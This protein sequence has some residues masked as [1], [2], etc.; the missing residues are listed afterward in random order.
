MTLTESIS[1]AGEQSV[2]FFR[3]L[4]ASDIMK[5]I[6][7]GVYYSRH[8][9]IHS[10]LIVPVGI[11]VIFTILYGLNIFLTDVIHFRF[12]SS[13]LGMLINLVI[14]C[15]MSV[16]SDLD[17]EGKKGRT[18][19]KISQWS[20]WLL[21][22]YLSLIKPSMNFTLKW[23]NVFFIPSFIILPLSSPITF[24]EC[25]KIAGVFVVGFLLLLCI[26]VYLLLGLQWVL[27]RYGLLS[28]E[29]T[30]AQS[31]KDDAE[32]EEEIELR[33]MNSIGSNQVFTS[34]RDD[35]TTIDISSLRSVNE[36][37]KGSTRAATFSQSPF[38]PQDGESSVLQSVNPQSIQQPEPSYLRSSG[39]SVYRPQS[40]A[41]S[42]GSVISREE[43]PYSTVS[44]SSDS[45]S[46]STVSYDLSDN[47]KFITIFITKYVDWILYLLLFFVSLPFYYVSSIHVFLPYHLGITVISYYLALLIPQKWP[48]TKK[49]AHPILILTAEILFVCFIGSLIYHHG[50]PRGFLDDLEYYKT[51]KT[52]LNLFNNKAMLNNGK[53]GTLSLDFTKTPKWPGCGDILSSLMDVSIVA[54]SLPMFSYRRDFVQNFWVLMPP[55]VVSICLTFFLYPV[56]CYHIGIQSERAIGFIGRSVT[57]A[58]GTPLI[59]SLDGSISLMAVCTI[60]SGICGVLVGD[61]LFK[62][63]RVSKGD[64]VTRGV[65][66]GINC[67]A[68]A[69]AHLLNVD[70]RAA[71]MSSLSFSFFGTVMVIL[72]AIGSI[73]DLIHSWVGL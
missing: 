52:Y 12:P 71:S 30:T 37:E 53:E 58:L 4:T 7:H 39:P 59:D 42:L 21:T 10:Y 31:H 40:V 45:T 73:R 36:P 17:P 15:T 6:T 27:R 9:L 8:H 2:L 65:S 60:L 19:K 28:A 34:M 54:L 38:D 25:L 49:F 26:D 24:I 70:P 32:A 33:D 63:L 16:L 46:E 35:I 13:V 44:A 72:A 29:E 56:F 50:K 61:T 47:A 41:T 57:L 68:I 5:G 3:S 43:Q 64:Y 14:I 69:T 11:V 23:I 20:N 55:I 48:Q 22:N 51:G 62:F 67:G 18:F 66:L 1:M